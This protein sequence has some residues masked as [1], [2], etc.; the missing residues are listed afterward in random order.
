LGQNHVLGS[1]LWCGVAKLGAQGRKVGA[2]QP[3]STVTAL[4]RG[5]LFEFRALFDSIKVSSDHGQHKE[6]P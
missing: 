5:R 4:S 3:A 6:P 2:S 1:F